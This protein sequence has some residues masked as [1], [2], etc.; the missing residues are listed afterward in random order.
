MDSIE[1]INH[2]GYEINIFFD[3][4]PLNPRTD[5]DNVG[6][7]WLYHSRYDIGDKDAIDFNNF[8]S[9]EDMLEYIEL[10]YDPAVILPVS[11]YDH[12]G[13]TV[14]HGEANGWDSGVI[15]FH[16]ITKADAIRNWGKKNLTKK[17]IKRCEKYLESEIS[18]Y[19]NYVKGNVYGY[20]VYD[21]DGN[22]IDG[23]WGFFGDD[24]DRNGLLD[25]AKSSIDFDIADKKEVAKKKADLEQWNKTRSKPYIE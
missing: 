8:R 17:I 3:E 21:D 18:E 4:N 14:F 22:N 7:L 16:F 2:K 5:F 10:E 11:M 6:K 24:F 23:C 25:H 19:D 1:I 15:G 13:V 12:S 9:W 20:E